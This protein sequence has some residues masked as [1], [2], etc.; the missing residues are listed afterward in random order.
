MVAFVRYIPGKRLELP[1]LICLTVLSVYLVKRHL[2][3]TLILPNRHGTARA[4][5]AITKN[6]RSPYGVTATKK[7][8]DCL[9]TGLEKAWLGCSKG[10]V[11][12]SLLG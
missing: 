9:L 12:R 5:F 6:N 2:L 3:K 11:K 4:F 10:V 1:K 8:S 7:L